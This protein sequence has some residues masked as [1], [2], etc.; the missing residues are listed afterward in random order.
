[1][2]LDLLG[3]Y[4][5]RPEHAALAGRR[6][7]ST[8]SIYALEC[9]HSRWTSSVRSR[10]GAAGRASERG[11]SGCCCSPSWPRSGPSTSRATRRA[12]SASTP[13]RYA[14]P[15]YIRTLVSYRC[16]A[17]GRAAGRGRS[18]R[19][20]LAFLLLFACVDP[21]PVPLADLTGAASGAVRG[22]QRGARTYRARSGRGGASKRSTSRTPWAPSPG[23]SSWT[24]PRL[25]R[26]PGTSTSRMLVA[27]GRRRAD[28]HRGGEET[29]SASHG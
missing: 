4:Y 18:E 19:A 29:R 22:P 10:R 2:V 13:S 11:G 5:W 1:M 16:P 23:P 25:R 27:A 17:P 28:R 6:S 26:R 20:S 12:R 15:A 7:P 14:L 3:T 9:G 8:A 21:H 24:V